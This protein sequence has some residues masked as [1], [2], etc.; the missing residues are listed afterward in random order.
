M[1]SVA[2]IDTARATGGRTQARLAVGMAVA[3]VAVAC[4]PAAMRRA[5]TGPGTGGAAARGGAVAGATGGNVGAGGSAGTG[6]APAASPDAP[7]PDA[8]PRLDAATPPRDATAPGD[9]TVAQEASVPD[10]SGRLIWPN[11]TSSKNSDPWLV[12]NHTR[13]EEMHPRFL[14]LDFANHF[15]DAQV[16]A[17]FN[18]HKEALMEGSR[19]HGYKNPDAK[20]FMIWEVFRHVNLK[21]NPIPPDAVSRNS[22]KMPRRNGGIDFG[23]LFSQTYAD[24]YRIPDPANPGR[25]M[26]ICD[27]FNAGLV[28]D[29]LVAFEKRPPDDNVPEV[30][31]LHQVY[32][33]NDMKVPGRF[34]PLAGNGYW[35]P[36]DVEQ[37]M[38][39]GRSVR[40]NFLEMT[41]NLTNAMEVLGHNFEHIG[42]RAMPRFWAMFRPFANMDMKTRY[43]LPFSDWYGVCQYG[44]PCLTYPDS[45][46]VTI[47]GNNTLRPL[48]QGCG[49][50]H[51]PPN[52]GRHYDKANPQEVLSTCEHYGL[53][54]GPGG[55]DLQTLY[56]VRTLDRWQNHPVARAMPGGAWFLYWW[57]NWPGY[58]NK[59]KMP[60]GTPMKNWWVYLYY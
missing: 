18:L 27:M 36:A 23:Q 30:L 17:R 34:D 14:I 12:A 42:S 6:G 16:M 47:L 15:T 19:Y 24:L 58:G 26:K 29:I 60:D 40:L 20:P 51:F 22:T 1:G 33:A 4:G 43:G 45:N 35:G 52:A 31:E 50:A 10:P 57:Q 59:A 3:L 37:V 55:R 13:I 49:N 11:E 56:S 39:C 54:D 8:A 2:T 53:A 32:D 44:Q 7:V 46:S 41:G 21:D 9:A 25:F 28:N 48:D 38:A 5:E